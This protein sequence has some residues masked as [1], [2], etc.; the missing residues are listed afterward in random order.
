MGT[1]AGLPSEACIIADNSLLVA[2]LHQSPDVTAEMVEGAIEDRLKNV[3]KL[4]K[5]RKKAE[6]APSEEGKAA[7]IDK[8]EGYEQQ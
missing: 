3:G 7:S 6:K 2:F 1:A 5:D 8:E 4:D